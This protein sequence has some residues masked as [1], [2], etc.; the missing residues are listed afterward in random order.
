MTPEKDPQAVDEDDY[1]VEVQLAPGI[2]DDVVALTAPD[3]KT[4]A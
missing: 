4:Q 2:E 3:D 1:N